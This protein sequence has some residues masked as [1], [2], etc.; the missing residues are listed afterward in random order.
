MMAISR[1]TYEPVA[2]MDAHA[3]PRFC[4]FNDL[5]SIKVRRRIPQVHRKGRAQSMLRTSIRIRVDGCSFHSV[6]GRGFSNASAYR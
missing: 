2:G 1:E 4:C 6:F 5:L 3:A